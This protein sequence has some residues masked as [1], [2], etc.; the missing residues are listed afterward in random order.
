QNLGVEHPRTAFTYYNLARTYSAQGRFEES[1]SLFIK[2]LNIRERTLGP[3][4]P[5]IRAMLE[6]YA[7]LLRKMKKE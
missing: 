5:S 1:E 6:H 3:D 4:H 7:I 2:A